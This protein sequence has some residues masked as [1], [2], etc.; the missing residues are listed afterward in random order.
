MIVWGDPATDDCPHRRPVL[1]CPQCRPRPLEHE[2]AD[3]L[4]TITILV[5]I[6]ACVGAILALASIG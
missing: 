3:T 2:L 5:A 1:A 6:G 4:I